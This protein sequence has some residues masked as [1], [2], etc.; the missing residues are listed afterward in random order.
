MYTQ[1]KAKGRRER[2]RGCN[3]KQARGGRYGDATTYVSR[4]RILQ[5]PPPHNCLCTCLCAVRQGRTTAQYLPAYNPA[6]ADARDVTTVAERRAKER[7]APHALQT[8]LNPSRRGPRRPRARRSARGREHWGRDSAGSAE[9]RQAR[10][11]RQGQG[12]ERRDE[13]Q[14]GQQVPASCGRQP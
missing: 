2:E 6:T 5:P 14:P 8:K 7:H 1:A 10:P 12:R 4:R 9:Q 13:Q 3:R 11:P